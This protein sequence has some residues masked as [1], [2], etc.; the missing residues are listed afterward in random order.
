MICKNCG[1]ELEPNERFCGN[2]GMAVS[3]EEPASDSPFSSAPLPVNIP[4]INPMP[5]IVFSI[6][7][8]VLCGSA[9]PG[10]FGLVFGIIADSRKTAGDFEG[11]KENLK[12]AK[13]ACWVGVGFFAFAFLAVCLLIF[14][15]LLAAVV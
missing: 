5:W 2:C 4:G 8:I 12:I 11:A 13:I 15:G 10:I 9:L 7:E 1:K 14:T 6:V 3:S